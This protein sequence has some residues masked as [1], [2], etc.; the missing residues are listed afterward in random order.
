MNQRQAHKHAAR[1]RIL[2]AASER[3][4]SE[5]L[6]GAAIAAVMRDADLT[7]GAFYAHFAN[8][9]ALAAAALGHALASNRERWVG[10]EQLGRDESW[11]QR[12]KRLAKRYLHIKHRDDWAS[13]CA[14]GALA[15]ESARSGP[16]FQATFAEEL[17][18][19]LDAICQGDFAKADTPI[20]QQSLAFMALCV[21]GITLARAVG[22]DDISDDILSACRKHAAALSA[23]SSAGSDKHTR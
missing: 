15:G 20:Q 23:F 19:S 12:L 8:K 18:R 5:G 3:L 22:D 21:G 6:G 2:E 13:S 17:K 16:A 14:L 7:H 1:E 11:P 4:C 9:D 10:D